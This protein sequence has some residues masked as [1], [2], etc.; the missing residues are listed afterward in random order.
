MKFFD[1][2]LIVAASV[3]DM[4]HKAPKKSANV[5]E[6]DESYRIRTEILA[7]VERMEQAETTRSDVSCAREGALVER[8]HE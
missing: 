7:R 5:G 4:T 8:W 2:A 1:R 3:A 6:N